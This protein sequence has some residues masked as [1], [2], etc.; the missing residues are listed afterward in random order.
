MSSVRR[1]DRLPDD[2]GRVVLQHRNSDGP[3]VQFLS[4]LTRF[5]EAGFPELNQRVR[6]SFSLAQEM[7]APHSRSSPTFEVDRI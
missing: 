5:R 2:G 7:G 3:V 6:L 1:E 4:P